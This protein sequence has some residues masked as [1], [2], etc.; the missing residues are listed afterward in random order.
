[1]PTYDLFIYV[2]TCIAED[3]KIELKKAEAGCG[4][5]Q[6]S[7][8]QACSI[9]YVY[10]TCI[11]TPEKYFK[12]PQNTNVYMGVGVNTAVI[13]KSSKFPP[14]PRPDKTLEG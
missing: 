11:P 14:P 3:E 6:V 9:L 8:D 12:I 2:F 13:E 5:S 4:R 10:S 7:S 1:M